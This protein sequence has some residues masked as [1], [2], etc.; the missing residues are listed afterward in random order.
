M[1]TFR[2]AWTQGC[3]RRRLVTVKLVLLGGL[4]LIGGAAV[5]VLTWW[6]FAPL[7]E[8]GAGRLASPQFVALGPTFTGWTLL[9]FGLGVALGVVS[10]RVLTAIGLALGAWTGLAVFT[11][12][13]GRYYLYRPPLRYSRPLASSLPRFHA[14]Q[15]AGYT[16]TAPPSSPV[17]DGAY[18]LHIWLETKHGHPLRGG[19]N[20]AP[21]VGVAPAPVGAAHAG[22]SA[23]PGGPPGHLPPALADA[24]RAGIRVAGTYQPGSRFWLFQWTETTW[25]AVLSLLLVAGAVMVTRRPHLAGAGLGVLGR[26]PLRWPGRPLLAPDRPERPRLGF[27]PLAYPRL[28]VTGLRWRG[29]TWAAWRQ[30]RAALRALALVY[31]AAAALLAINGLAIR[32]TYHQLGLAGCVTTRR[33]RR[34]GWG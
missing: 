7:G 15:Q 3:G 17:P 8:L 4:L 33:L 16:V 18:V 25:L 19:L 34:A 9:A 27:P 29:V 1:G 31:A 28:A 13:W 6:W 23:A 10:R 2:F 32:G 26:L 20:V 5:T 12:V 22:P 21:R 11:G 24:I 30:H 14:A